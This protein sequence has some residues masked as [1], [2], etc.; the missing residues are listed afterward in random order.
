MM[1]KNSVMLVCNDVCASEQFQSRSVHKNNCVHLMN[2]FIF[3]RGERVA[4]VVSPDPIIMIHRTYLC[5]GPRRKSERQ[6][7]D[8]FF[9]FLSR[10]Q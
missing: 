8:K 4:I 1:T 10:L 6:G 2:N 3:F 9:F 7:L 5:V